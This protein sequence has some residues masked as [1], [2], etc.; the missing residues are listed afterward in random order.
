MQEQQKLPQFAVIAL[1]AHTIEKQRELD[2]QE[3]EVQKD[4]D[5]L[6][7]S[8]K[9]VLGEDADEIIAGGELVRRGERRDTYWR[10]QN[11]GFKSTRRGWCGDADRFDFCVLS[12][13][14]NYT[15][16]NFWEQV[17]KLVEIGKK[18]NEANKELAKKAK[19]LQEKEDVD[20]EPVR[21]PEARI[22]DS[23]A[24]RFQANRPLPLDKLLL[25]ITEFIDN[26]SDDS[27]DSDD[28]E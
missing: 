28:D 20:N 23:I 19:R 8:L 13:E 22:F 11:F 27:D 12:P 24:Y 10:Y 9:A 1:D 26:G 7:E 25:A 4:I 16:I 5:H 17:T 14:D 6:F 21:A 2:K 3:S 15:Q 18:I